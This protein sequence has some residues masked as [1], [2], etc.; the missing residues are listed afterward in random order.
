MA[1]ISAMEQGIPIPNIKK[2]ELL[3]K[4]ILFSAH[5]IAL[6]LMIIQNRLQHFHYIFK[7]LCLKAITFV[8]LFL[9]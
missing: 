6:Q 1:F 7:L 8:I 2:Q 5:D 4:F 9:L 3:L